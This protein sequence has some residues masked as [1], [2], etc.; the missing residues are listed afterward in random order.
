MHMAA[1]NN[2]TEGVQ[3]LLRY[4]ADKN[5]K[6]DDGMT[7]LDMARSVDAQAVITLLLGSS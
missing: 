3:L 7:S 2:Y 1:L 5:F 6:D 4:H